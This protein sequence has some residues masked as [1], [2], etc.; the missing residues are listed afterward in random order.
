MSVLIKN[1]RIVTAADDYRADIFIR[2]TTVTL[3]GKD[4]LIESDHVIDAA[5]KLVIPGGVDPHTHLGDAVRRHHDIGYLRDRHPRG[6]LSA[7]PPV[8]SISPFSRKIPRL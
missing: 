8:S 1:G 3:I 4:L 5:G 2:D 6:S 7:A